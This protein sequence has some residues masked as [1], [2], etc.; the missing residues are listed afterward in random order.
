MSRWRASRSRS[1][2]SRR[3]G[4]D[5][6]VERYHPLTCAGDRLR[7][8]LSRC[9]ACPRRFADRHRD[10]G[11]T[12]RD[13]PPG[14]PCHAARPGH[15]PARIIVLESDLTALASYESLDPAVATV[16]PEGIVSPRGQVKPRWWSVMPGTRAGC[17]FVSNSFGPI[18]PVDF[19]TE[20]VAA[21]G[22]GGVTRVPAMARLK[23]RGFPSQ[24]AG[25]DPELDFVT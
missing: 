6:D 16:T 4:A 9:G 19:R 15:G 20:V 14:Q 17:R 1:L 3:K 7:R 25:F 23:A 5:L 13:R 2:W 18:P 12:G 22:R 21:F 24:P 10:L 11:A 8:Y